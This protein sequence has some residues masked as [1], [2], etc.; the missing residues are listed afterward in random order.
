MLKFLSLLVVMLGLGLGLAACGGSPSSLQLCHELC[1]TQRRCGALTDATA[2]N[3]H[4]SC[5][6]MKGSLADTD[7]SND[8]NCKNAGSIRSS[9]ESCLGQDCNKVDPCLN[10][11]DTTCVV[12]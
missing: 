5:D 3:C 4:T 7:S 11:I 12:K 10:A 2:S 1:D 8:R 9:Q 6:S